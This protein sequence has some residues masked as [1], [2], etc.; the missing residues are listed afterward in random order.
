MR[1][2]EFSRLFTKHPTSDISHLWY[3]TLISFKQKTEENVVEMI[4]LVLFS[5]IDE[6]MNIVDVATSINES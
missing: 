1:I 5:K 4:I 6:L 2:V 3:E